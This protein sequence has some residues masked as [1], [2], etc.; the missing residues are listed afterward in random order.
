MANPY[1]KQH[2]I[3]LEAERHQANNHILGYHP[4]LEIADSAA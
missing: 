4:A 2:W 1:Y 3:E